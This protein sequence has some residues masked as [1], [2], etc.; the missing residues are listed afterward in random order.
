MPMSKSNMC[1][2]VN[3]M[4]KP[5]KFQRPPQPPRSTDPRYITLYLGPATKRA[6]KAVRS[7]P[8]S[9]AG[10]MSRAARINSICERYAHFVHEFIP[11]LGEAEWCGLMAI[12][13]GGISPELFEE[14][15]S[16]DHGFW[17]H[18]RSAH[19]AGAAS[20]WNYDRKRLE[21]ALDGSSDTILYGVAEVV[22]RFWSSDLDDGRSPLQRFKDCG[23]NVT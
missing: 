21:N 5:P 4:T 3:E 12:F 13:E 14:L 9:E 16:A 7:Y 17:E 11:T 23:A 10:G 15:R 18:V 1:Y 6:L 20:E 22:D 2:M 19:E 8:E